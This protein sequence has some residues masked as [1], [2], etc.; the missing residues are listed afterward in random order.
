MM[1]DFAASGSEGPNAPMS[2]RSWRERRQTQECRGKPH[3][4]GF[5]MVC[6]ICGR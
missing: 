1:V 5:R 6:N 3:V 2:P 4:T